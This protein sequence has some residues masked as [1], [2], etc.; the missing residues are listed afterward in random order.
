[1]GISQNMSVKCVFHTD[2]IEDEGL[3]EQGA[4][5]SSWASEG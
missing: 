5:K 4:I 1:M 3:Q 2:R